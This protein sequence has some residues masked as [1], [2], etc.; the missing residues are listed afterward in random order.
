MKGFK[1]FKADLTCRG[2]FQY[3]IGHSYE[4][5][6]EPIPGSRGFHF[7]KSIADAYQFYSMNKSTRICEV[8][9]YGDIKTDTEI[10]YCT[11]KIEI[12]RE[13]TDDWE[14]RG[15]T[16]ASSDGFC[17]TGSFNTGNRNTGDYNT[18]DFNTGYF[19]A[20][21]HNAGNGNTGNQNTGSY[22]MDSFN[23]GTR[24]TGNRNAGGCN[25]GKYNT[26]DYNTGN[27][28]T[29]DYNAGNGNTGSHNT[30]DCNA[31]CYNIG[32][33]NTGDFNKGNH[34]SGCFN[35]RAESDILMF[36][37]PSG[38][39]FAQWRSSEARFVLEYCPSLMAEWISSN[40]MTDEEKKEHPEY[41][42]TEGYLRVCDESETRQAWWD[43]L[44]E[45]S[46][47]LVMNL[48]NFDADIFEQCTGIKV[49]K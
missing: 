42:T 29:G 24:N 16:A 39:T 13:I 23:T 38:W 14:R 32:S 5:D 27:Y 33:F 18:G 43:G 35:T 31:G 25:T 17:N 15:N 1:A 12:V 19:N 3:E 30:G 20:G 21:G 41:N 46:K 28:N 6:E 7:C 49:K 44:A 47:T 9:A 2:G 37:K 40:C 45:S 26:G 4:M 22:N 36:N 48:P 11:N 10:K 8:E 34:F